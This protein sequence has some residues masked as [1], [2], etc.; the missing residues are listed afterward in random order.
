MKEWGYPRAI[1][2]EDTMAFIHKHCGQRHD[3]VAEA[4]ACQQVEIASCHWLV[5]EF[6]EDGVRHV[7]CGA[8]AVYTQRGW[9]CTQGHSHVYSEFRAK[10]GWDYSDGPHDAKNLARFGIFP[11]TMDGT[12]PAEIA[13]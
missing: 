3:L 7:D 11:M 8:N 12:G 9:R 10:E 4:R 1:P 2:P 5:E 6:T 13:P